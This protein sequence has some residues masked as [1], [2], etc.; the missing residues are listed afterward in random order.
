M[1]EFLEKIREARAKA[2]PRKFVQTWTLSFG[3]KNIDLKK[4]ENRFSSDIAL[5]EGKGKKVRTVV[6]A[7]ALAKEAKETADYVI[8]K[9]QIPGL[10]RDTKKLRKMATDYD[11]F[12]GEASLMPQIGKSFGTVLGPKGKMPKPI[13]PNTKLGP[14]LEAFKKMITVSLKNSPV[15]HAVI[16]TEDMDDEK[17]ARNAQAVYNLVRDRLPKGKANIKSMHV[18]LTMGPPSRLN[19]SQV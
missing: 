15:I 6:I 2:K 16:G 10:S 8:E 7:D 19:I 9:S 18:K 1:N 14:F 13:P 4:P 17:V 3:L 11:F 5:P 12:F